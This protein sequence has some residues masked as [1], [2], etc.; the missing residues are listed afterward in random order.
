MSISID[1]QIQLIKL[2]SLLL[3][4]TLIAWDKVNANL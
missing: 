1:H 3:L 2:S 4:D